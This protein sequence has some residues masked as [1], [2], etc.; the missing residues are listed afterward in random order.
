MVPS[1]PIMRNQT[2]SDLTQN[3]VTIIVHS[4][5][6]SLLLHIRLGF[7][8]RKLLLVTQCIVCHMNMDITCVKWQIMSQVSVV[9]MI[10]F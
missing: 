2:S 7:E 4:V 5:E 8:S 1:L 10:S 6:M 9:H 3:I